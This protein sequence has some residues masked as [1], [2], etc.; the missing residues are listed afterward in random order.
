NTTIEKAVIAYTKTNAYAEFTEKE[1][2]TLMPGMVA[3]VVVLSQDIFSIPKEQ[4]PATKSV[5][6]I[7]NGKVV[8]QEIH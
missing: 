6:T 5:L 2:G 3:D 7:I 4:L 1:K 8:Y